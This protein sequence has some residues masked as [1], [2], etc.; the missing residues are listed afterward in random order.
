MSRF[1][2]LS[3]FA[4][5][6][7]LAIPQAAAGHTRKRYLTIARGEHAIVRA[8][9]HYWH[10]VHHTVQLR[11]GDCTRRS[12]SAVRCVVEIGAVFTTIKGRPGPFQWI[13]A[14]AEAHLTYRGPERHNGYPP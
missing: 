7:L 13:P 2:T 3:T 10:S 4:V 5:L 12:A 9:V 6:A 11:V 14:A 8:E 1:A